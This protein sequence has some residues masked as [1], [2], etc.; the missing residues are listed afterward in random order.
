[1]NA[2]AKPY[3][4]LSATMFGLVC[5]AHV[6]R[7]LNATPVLVDGWNV[8]LAVSWVGALV[9]AVLSIWGFRLALRA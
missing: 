9:T 8:P 4:M 1:M 5:L 2:I 3:L 7:L 6:V